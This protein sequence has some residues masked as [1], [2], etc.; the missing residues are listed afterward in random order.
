[1]QFSC[2]NEGKGTLGLLLYSALV[3]GGD[4]TPVV[5]GLISTLCC[6]GTLLEDISGFCLYVLI[7]LDTVV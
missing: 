2:G 4:T 6:E 1:M 7:V 5:V 3:D